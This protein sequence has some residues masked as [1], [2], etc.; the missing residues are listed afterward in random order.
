MNAGDSSLHV[1]QWTPYEKTLP[2]PSHSAIRELE[3]I[4]EY[5]DRNGVETLT[6]STSIMIA[7]GFTWRMVDVMVTNFHQ[8][9]STLLLL[10]SSFLDRDPERERRQWRHIY[11]EALDHAYRFLS[12]GDACLLF[13][14]S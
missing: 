5:M 3:S 2:M 9:Q 13:P 1:D 7:P 11:N 8:P 14:L 4:M 6:A 10:V 12:Y